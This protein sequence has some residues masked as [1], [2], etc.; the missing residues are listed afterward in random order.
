MKNIRIFWV[1]VALSFGLLLAGCDAVVTDTTDGI[2]AS[3][4]VEVVE[5]V[6]A[7][8][9]NGR[10]VELGIEQGDAVKAGD[11]LF[12]LENEILDAQHDQ[13]I[14]AVEA[15]QV[16]LTAM[17]ASQMSAEAGVESARLGLEIARFQ[18]ETVLR[19]VRL[20]EMERRADSWN[21]EPPNEFDLPSWYFSEEEEIK[22]AEEEVGRAYE[23]LQIEK[24]NLEDLL[25]NVS[26]ADIR[27]VEERLATSQFSFE[28]AQELIDREVEQNGDDSID[29]YLQTV[30]DLA[31]AELESAQANYESILTDDGAQEILD[32]RA[33]VIVSDERYQLA[34]ANLYQLN[35]GENSLEVVIAELGVQQAETLLIQAE[36]GLAQA[37][38]GMLQ[39][40]KM[41]DQD[42]SNLDLIKLQIEKLTVVS[43]IDGVVMVKTIEVGELLQP[44]VTA[45]TL[46]LLDDLTITVYV[47]EETYGRIKL[48]DK[49]EV[50]VDSFENKVFSAVVTRIADQAEYTPRN[51][52][53]EEDRRTT[54]FAI[55]L[56]V[57][58]TDGML[59]PGMPA[60]VK[61]SN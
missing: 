42:Q 25:N 27:V 50:R 47:P 18:Y 7:S 53:T 2:E 15:A 3:G 1:V 14:A 6:V 4:V 23:E 54:V 60:D 11:T 8:E 44:G 21:G 32:A 17:D 13:A 37:Q 26:N 20:G 57:S 31:E 38:A 58:D 35:R 43:R 34:L 5:I 16:N 29:D 9:V 24:E 52:Q 30:F 55:E 41:L 45:M 33:R 40:E 12:V 36:A 59:K 19:A 51:V 28:L 39:A 56:S 61:F 10:V 49:A 46:G 48:G 22:I